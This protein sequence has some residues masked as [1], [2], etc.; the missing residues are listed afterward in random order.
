M[1]GDDGIIDGQYA[2]WSSD[3][4]DVMVVAGG[5]GGMGGRGDGGKWA[6]YAKYPL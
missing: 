5:G 3:L 6:Q 1:A 2:L 4:C